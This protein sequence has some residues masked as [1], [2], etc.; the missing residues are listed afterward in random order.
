MSVAI[1]TGSGG[2]VGVETARPFLGT[3]ILAVAIDNDIFGTF[4]RGE[5]STRRPVCLRKKQS[6]HAHFAGDMWDAVAVSAAFRRHGRNI[7]AVTHV[8][9][10]VTAFWA[11]LQRSAPGRVFNFGDMSRLMVDVHAGG[12]SRMEVSCARQ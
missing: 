4:V 3:C 5:A 12:G 2:L 6:A 11:F 7:A 9:D 10:A 1:A 8:R